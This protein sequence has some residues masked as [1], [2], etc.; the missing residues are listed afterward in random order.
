MEIISPFGPTIGHFKLDEGRIQNLVEICERNKNDTN[1][2]LNH[3]LVGFIEKEFN[4]LEELKTELLQIFTSYV[5][6]YLNANEGAYKV[7]K[8][9]KEKDIECTSAWC[10]IQEPGEFNPVHNHALADLVCV[11]YPKVNVDRTHNKYNIKQNYIPGG[12]HFLSQSSDCKFSSHLY[13]TF[14]DVGSVYVFPSTLMH[15]TSPFYKEKDERW[16]V[17]MNFTFTQNFLYFKTLKA[18]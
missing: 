1:K 4:I 9:Y 3:L 14:P 8:P 18:R 5:V 17:S 11:V 12:V 13:E 15:Y 10:N 16:S 7:F 6:Q 2:K